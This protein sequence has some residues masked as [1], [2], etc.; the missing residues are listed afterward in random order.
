MIKDKM[1]FIQKIN[2]IIKTKLNRPVLRNLVLYA[3]NYCNASC[4]TCDVV[5]KTGT[6][7]ARPL[8]DSPP[9]MSMKLFSKILADKLVAGKHLYINFLM[10]EPLLAPDLPKMAKYCKKVGH[11]VKITTNGFL[12]PKRAHE[13]SPY[14]DNI[15]ISID[16]PEMINDSIRGKGFFKNAVDGIKRLRK[17]NQA[18]EIEV[19]CTVSPMNYQY[20]YPLARELDQLGSR[21][22]LMKFQFLDFVSQDMQQRHNVHYPEIP[23]T[24]SCNLLNAQFEGIDAEHL[25]E[26]IMRIKKKRLNS[27]QRMAFKPPVLDTDE[28]K[29]YFSESGEKL[30]FKMVCRTPWQAISI[31]T[32]GTAFWHMRCFND[33]ELGNIDTENLQMIFYGKKAEYFRSQLKHSRFCF[34]ACTRC[35]GVM[36]MAYK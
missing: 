23:Q 26:Q 13:I 2:Q 10:T 9:H 36:P 6:G 32:D 1:E 17:I 5:N 15:Q 34:P 30:T 12:L 35:C 3:N 20:L 14:I 19:N 28:I 24:I 18:V 7:I 31:A 4:K 8:N 22:D 25:K 33:Y 27:I 29:K 11:T 21:I 16:G